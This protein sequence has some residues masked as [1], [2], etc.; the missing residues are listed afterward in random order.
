[1]VLRLRMHMMP[2]ATPCKWA[3]EGLR[4]SR[5]WKCISGLWRLFATCTWLVMTPQRAFL[6][7][8]LSVSLLAF[9]ASFVHWLR[10]FLFLSVANHRL[11]SALNSAKHVRCG[12]TAAMSSAS[13]IVKKR[14][15]SPVLN[16][17][18]QCTWRMSSERACTSSDFRWKPI[19]PQ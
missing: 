2:R 18:C 7:R 17:H 11:R 12:E 8:T 13:S 10:C 5:T 6:F 19:H 15:S 3:Q 1:M 4:L 9:L 16:L 14:H